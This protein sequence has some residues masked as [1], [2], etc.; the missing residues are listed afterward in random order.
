VLR[1]CRNE[2][3]G[4]FV[5]FSILWHIYR[6][7]AAILVILIFS[8]TPFL[9]NGG[10]HVMSNTLPAH[11][12]RYQRSRDGQQITRELITIMRTLK[13]QGWR[14]RRSV[15]DA[16][17]WRLIRDHSEGFYLLRCLSP[18]KWIVQPDTHDEEFT[19]LR[20]AVLEVLKNA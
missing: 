10:N 6:K 9:P 13:A 20:T 12:G 7:S 15:N 8:E 4:Y 11:R 14:S 19:N 3:A 1:Y 2:I 17:A 16:R 5:K 18:G